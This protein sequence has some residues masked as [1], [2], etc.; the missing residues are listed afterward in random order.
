MDIPPPLRW[1]EQDQAAREWLSTVPGLLERCA[2]RWGLSL[3]PPFPTCH[4]SWTCPATR[5]GG[6]TVVLKLQFPHPEAEHEADAL[7]HWSGNGAVRLLDHAPELHALLIERCE[8]GDHLSTRPGEEALEV[9]LDLLRRLSVS[10]SR[11]FK[12]LTVEAAEWSDEIPRAYERTGRP[13]EMRVVD[14]ALEA[15][16]VLPGSQRETV[17]LHQ[18]LHADNVLA[19]GQGR[20]LAID[21]KPL[22]G[23][24]AF[25]LAPVIRSTELGHSREAVIRRLRHGS[26]SL[27]LDLE[28]VRGWA[29][30]Q[31]VAWA[32]T[33]QSAIIRHVETARWLLEDAG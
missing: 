16:A 14:A 19:A 10:A 29:I 33:H 6:D 17:L 13:F 12:T 22:V 20:W 28:R 3:G 15:L 23:E 18:D 26:R 4:V 32:F 5:A 7:R 9:I 27:G 31:T 1:M 2:S 11:P 25:A 21:P 24:R 8:P 30:A